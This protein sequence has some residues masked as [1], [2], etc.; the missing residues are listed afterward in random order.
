MAV[1]SRALGFVFQTSG[2]L[3]DERTNRS[4]VGLECAHHGLGAML[5]QGGLIHH[6]DQGRQY[7]STAYVETPNSK[8]RISSRPPVLQTFRGKEPFSGVAD[9]EKERVIVPWAGR[10]ELLDQGFL[11]STHRLPILPVGILAVFP[12]GKVLAVWKDHFTFSG[13]WSRHEN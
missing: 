13:D 10:S 7:S 1:F 5:P 4:A 3:G 12:S 9:C 6:T 8:K 11:V 2:G